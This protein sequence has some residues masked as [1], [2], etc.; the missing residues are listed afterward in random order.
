MSENEHHMLELL[1][2][3]GAKGMVLC[4]DIDPDDPQYIKIRK[5][6]KWTQIFV[7]H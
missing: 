3:R 7:T 1:W 4:S 2:W 6:C 5:T